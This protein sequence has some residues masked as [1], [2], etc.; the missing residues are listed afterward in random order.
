MQ[1]IRTYINQINNRIKKI[2]LDNIT[3]ITNY[4]FYGSG[5]TEVRLDKIKIICMHSFGKTNIEK[6]YIGSSITQMDINA[7]KGCINIEEIVIE[8][9][10]YFEIVDNSLINS[11]TKEVIATIKWG[12]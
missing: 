8:D 11:E 12:V 6:L 9:N 2:N 7:F 10:K 5:L 3:S 1:Q 4:A